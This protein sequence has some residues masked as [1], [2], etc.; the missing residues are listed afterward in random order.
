MAL[1][2][3]KWFQPAIPMVDDKGN[4]VT[5][6]LR[7]MTF[8][9]EI[10]SLPSDLLKLHELLVVQRANRNESVYMMVAAWCKLKRYQQYWKSFH[11][12]SEQEYLAYYDLPEGAT[13]AS[14]EVMVNLFDKPTFSLLGD[15]V[16]L[17]MTRLIG[18][19]QT[20]PDERKRDYQTIFDQYCKLYEAF[21]K[22]TFYRT[23]RNYVADKYEKVAVEGGMTREAW[24]RKKE[25]HKKNPF[26]PGE[27]K[28]RFTRKASEKQ[29]YGPRIERDFDWRVEQCSSCK[30]K[31]RIIEDLLLQLE[32]CEELIRKRLGEKEVPERPVTIRDLHV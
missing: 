24:K 27:R 30:P 22:T 31:V 6:R 18:Y 11:F 16:I 20:D 14:W 19:F 1:T 23:V 21:D 32:V 7:R 9:R 28:R 8:A 5:L 13:L 25:D 3:E 26:R 10:D 2:A 4:K 15:Q 17:F 12:G 29:E